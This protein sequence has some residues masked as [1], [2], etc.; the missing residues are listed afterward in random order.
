M[1]TPLKLF[2]TYINEKLETFLVKGH[3]I[4]TIQIE[5]LTSEIKNFDIPFNEPCVDCDAYSKEVIISL[6]DEK[7][8][9]KICDLIEDSNNEHF[10]FAEKLMAK[11]IFEMTL[12]EALSEHYFYCNS[13]SWSTNHHKIKK[14]KQQIDIANFIVKFSKNNKIEDNHIL[15]AKKHKVLFEILIKSQAPTGEKT[16]S[17]L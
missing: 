6:S 7:E 3:L 1:N 9:T 11:S 15:L 13:N 5:D 17:K 14:I 10:E 2:E 16:P 4:S 12:E 8:I